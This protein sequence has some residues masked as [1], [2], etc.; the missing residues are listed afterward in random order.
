[1]A[2]ITVMVK[3]YKD[4]AQW[5]RVAKQGTPDL[6]ERRFKLANQAVGEI[7]VVSLESKEESGPVFFS[8]VFEL[9]K[10]PVLVEVVH[11]ANDPKKTDYRSAATWMMERATVNQ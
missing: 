6:V 8:Y 5:I 7:T 11:R 10:T 2:T 3:T 1:M 4:V 9:Q